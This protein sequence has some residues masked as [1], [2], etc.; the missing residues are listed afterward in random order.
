MSTFQRP[1][2]WA[3]APAADTTLKTGRR[4]NMTSRVNDTFVATQATV[5]VLDIV[6]CVTRHT[7]LRSVRTEKL[8]PERRP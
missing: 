4:V 1:T 5:P 6:L 7:S 3:D 2:I 8:E